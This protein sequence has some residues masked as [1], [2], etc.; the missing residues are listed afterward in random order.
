ME[1]EE[2]LRK[3][4]EDYS[5]KDEAIKD[6]LKQTRPILIALLAAALFLFWLDGKYLDGR[7]LSDAVMLLAF[8]A[9]C[10]ED[11]YI[12]TVTRKKIYL[13]TSV[14]LAVDVLMKG[15]MLIETAKDLI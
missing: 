13:F 2:I 11:F 15:Y 10:A 14:L 9:I 12:F 4:R 3:S 8:A 5:E 1:K 7:M 6:H